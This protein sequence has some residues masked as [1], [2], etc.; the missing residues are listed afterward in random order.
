MQARGERVM[1]TKTKPTNHVV[2]LGDSIFD[3]A[4]YVDGG[5]D[6]IQHLRQCLPSRWAATLNAVDGSVTRDVAEQLEALP[7][8]A[9]HLVLSI[10]GNDVLGLADLL[11]ERARSVAEALA[12]LADAHEAFHGN[13]RTMLDGVMNAGLP[14]ADCRLPS[15]RSTTPASPRHDAGGWRQPRLRRLTTASRAR[16]LCAGCR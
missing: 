11:D 3:N 1:L 15:A 4:R 16:P 10:G 9:S 2:L 14:T 8:D 12:K 7:H 6:V 5:P 13:Y